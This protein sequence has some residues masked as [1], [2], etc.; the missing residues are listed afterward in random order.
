MEKERPKVGVGVVVQKEGKVLL[1]KRKNA[2]GAGEW[3]FPGGHLEFF[4]TVEACALRELS[5]ETSLQANVVR[6]GPWTENIMYG[7]HYI[8]LFAFVD[9]FHG[10]PQVMEEE[11]CE[12]WHWFS[13]EELPEP[14]FPPIISLRQHVGLKQVWTV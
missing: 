14:L 11:K 9:E 8:T 7:K 6:L 12:G 4:E 2:H 1:G 3:S 13:W 5:E 10:V